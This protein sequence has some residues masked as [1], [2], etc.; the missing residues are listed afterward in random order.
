MTPE[1]VIKQSIT[2]SKKRIESACEAMGY[3]DIMQ[4]PF[5]NAVASLAENEELIRRLVNLQVSRIKVDDLLIS[6]S[7][8]TEVAS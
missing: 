3:G 6:S 8:K 5:W 4:I 1:Q 7:L 2:Q